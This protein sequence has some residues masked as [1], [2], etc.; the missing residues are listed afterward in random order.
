EVIG[1]G[2]T[3]AGFDV[4]ATQKESSVMSGPSPTNAPQA[5]LKVLLAEDNFVNQKLAL[6]MLQK[7]G[8]RVTVAN[9]GIEA[10]AQ[11]DRDAFD[12][13]LMD[14]H[15]PNMGGFEATAKIRE[16]E[17]ARGTGRIPIIALTALAM[18]G[19]R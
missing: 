13:V 19:D 9:D 1:A 7:R 10:L 8:H 6:T 17:R 15:M 12:V 2:A 11:L 3:P 4:S 5:S 18:S 16:D 14:V